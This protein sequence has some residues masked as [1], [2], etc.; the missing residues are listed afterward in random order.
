MSNP[1]N[2][3]GTAGMQRPPSR[4]VGMLPV[5]FAPA[6]YGRIL[7]AEDGFSSREAGRPLPV[8]W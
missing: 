4:M 7:L 5:L 2:L 8:S 3:P 6:Q 1:R